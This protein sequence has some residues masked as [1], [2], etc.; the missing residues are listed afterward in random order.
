MRDFRDWFMQIN[1]C[2]QNELIPII[3]FSRQ[4]ATG[5][6]NAVEHEVV[7]WRKPDWLKGAKEP[8]HGL[9]I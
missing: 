8:T 5:E 6:S 2:A 1:A 9:P 3:A 7:G 4:T